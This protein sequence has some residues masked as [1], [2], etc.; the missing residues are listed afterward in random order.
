MKR[1]AIVLGATALAVTGLGPTPPDDAAA[2]ST[3]ESPGYGATRT[4]ART[5]ADGPGYPEGI[6]V[7]G[8]WVFVTAAAVQGT[9]G[10]GPSEIYVYSLSDG[11][12]VRTIEVTGQ[13]LS[14]E[15]AVAGTAADGQGRL[16]VVETQQGVLRFDPRNG[17]Q[18][19]TYGGP[20]PDLPPCPASVDPAESPTPCSPTADD[21]PPLPN[22]LAFDEAGNLYYTDSFQNTIWY[23]PSGGGSPRIWYQDDFGPFGPNGIELSPD[24]EFLYFVTSIPSAV[25]R[26]PVGAPPAEEDVELVTFLDPAEAGGADGMV[27]GRSGRLYVSLAFLNQIAVVDPSTGEVARFPGPDENASLD[28]PYDAPASLAWN[29]RTRSLLVVNH[30]TVSGNSDNFGVLEAWVDDLP[31]RVATPS[32]E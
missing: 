24:G 19:E 23:Y 15:H 4:F 16:Y 5:P 3:S 18:Q 26:V 12:L 31:A 8:R 21:Q 14:Q 7:V 9:A 1:L 10:T 22:D 25:Y 32:V 17:Y 29:K 6:E 2:R 27:F 28:M 11:S 13:D 30:A 20:L